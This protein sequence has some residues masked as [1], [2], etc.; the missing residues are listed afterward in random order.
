LV[1]TDQELV[2]RVPI[3]RDELCPQCE[4]PEAIHL[5]VEQPNFPLMWYCPECGTIWAWYIARCPDCDG[6]AW[7]KDCPDDTVKCSMCGMEWNIDTVK[8]IN[9]DPDFHNEGLED[10]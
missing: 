1:T 10:E 3:S 2:P 8:E 4:Y 7:N 9:E 5:S 6:Y